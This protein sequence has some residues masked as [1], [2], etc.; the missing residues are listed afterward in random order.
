MPPKAIIDIHALS[1]DDRVRM[2]G[3]TAS[4][5]Q[6][7]G[8]VVD[9]DAAADRYTEKIMQRYPSVIITWRANSNGCVWLKAERKPA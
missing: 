4:R 9:N 1:E 8:F 7:V 5:G 6:R 2:V 3:E